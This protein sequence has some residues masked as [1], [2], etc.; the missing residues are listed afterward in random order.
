VSWRSS[1]GH[2]GLPNEGGN[3]YI[4]ALDANTPEG[5]RDAIVETLKGKGAQASRKQ[6]SLDS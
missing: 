4:L 6:P 3:R 1:C 5:T 2:E